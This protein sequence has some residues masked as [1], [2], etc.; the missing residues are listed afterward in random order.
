[1]EMLPEGHKDKE[2]GFFMDMPT[3]HVRSIAT[4]REGS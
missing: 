1:M 3:K 2:N 4:Q